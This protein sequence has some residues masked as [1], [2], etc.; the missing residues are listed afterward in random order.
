V[1]GGGAG[2]TLKRGGIALRA[3]RTGLRALSPRPRWR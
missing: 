2:P 1:H 3:S